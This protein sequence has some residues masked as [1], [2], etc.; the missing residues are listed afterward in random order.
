M[1]SRNSNTISCRIDIPFYFFLFFIFF[2]FIEDLNEDQTGKPNTI[3]M[4]IPTTLKNFFM[5]ERKDRKI[6]KQ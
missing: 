6:T 1:K 3:E 5:K 2:I 4:T